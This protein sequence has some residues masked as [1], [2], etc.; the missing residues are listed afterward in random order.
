VDEGI[1]RIALDTARALGAEYADVRAV[2]RRRERITVRNGKVHRA[3]DSRTVGFGV[4]V[5]YDGAWGFASSSRM[6]RE[7]APKIAEE[8]VRIARASARQGGKRATL[9]PCRPHRGKYRTKVKRDPFEVP[10]E[11]KITLLM[12]CDRLMRAGGPVRV[13]QGR[14]ECF[15]EQKWFLSSEGAC[16][17][18]EIV[19]C[20][21]GIEAAASAGGEIQR[22]SYPNA[23][24]G[25][26]A[27]AGYEFV[28]EMDLREHAE[29]VGREAVQLLEADPCPSLTTDLI[30]DGRQLAMQLHESCGHP[31]ELDRVLGQEVSLAGTSF[32]TPDDLGQFRFGSQEV[33]ITADATLERGLGTYG[34]D[35]EGVPAQRVPLVSEGI[36]VGFMSSRETAARIGDES[37]GCMRADGHNRLPLVRMTNVNL[38]PGDWS[39]EELI[40]DTREGVFMEINRSWSIDDRRLNF[41]FG[42]ECAWMIEEGSLT[43]MIKGATYTGITPQFWRSCDAVCSEDYWEL[44]GTPNCGKGEPGQTAHVGHGAAPARFRRV[45]VGV[46]RL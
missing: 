14:L 20:G 7:V 41:Q 17:Q 24:R 22:R 35:D 12:D 29:R 9:A 1:L 26:H 15:R 42:V 6:D 16:I 45:K 32:L 39:L 31:M 33:N 38:E 36:L 19:E 21:G 34:Y 40:R 18:Q 25:H 37:N 13:T 11:E 46:R 8:A 3:S 23:H 10:L 4:R 27:T 2:A 5:L 44:W 30:L 43:R 28:E